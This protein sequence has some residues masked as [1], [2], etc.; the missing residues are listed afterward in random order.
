MGLSIEELRRSVEARHGGK[1]TF[2]QSVPVI[3]TFQGKPV[4]VG[5]VQIFDLAG[6]PE[7]TRAYA[8]SS[9]IEGSIK[10]RFFGLLHFGA[11]QSPLDAVRATIVAER[12]SGR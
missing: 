6:H 7:A 12:R 3:E 9:A 8:W 11:I 5:V 1:A 10:R 4:W 2:V